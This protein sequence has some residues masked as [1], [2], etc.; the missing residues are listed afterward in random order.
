MLFRVRKG[1]GLVCESAEVCSISDPT[2]GASVGL[3]VEPREWAWWYQ[4]EKAIVF[5][6]WNKSNM[7]MLLPRCRKVDA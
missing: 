6:V 4:D 7:N 3:V 5:V 2:W 1:L